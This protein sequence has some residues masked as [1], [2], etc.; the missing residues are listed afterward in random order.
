MRKIFI[1]MF[2]FICVITRAQINDEYAVGEGSSYDEALY[3]LSI[4]IGVDVD[5]VANLMRSDIR[6]RVSETF[7]ETRTVTTSLSA[8]G[9]E[10]KMEGEKY[11][12]RFNKSAYINSHLE[13]Y[14]Y[15]MSQAKAIKG[16]HIKHEKNLILGYYY[17]AYKALSDDLMRK[18]YDSKSKRQDIVTLAKDMYS[19]GSYGSLFFY[20]DVT[21]GYSIINA[22]NYNYPSLFGFKYYLD[23]KWVYPEAYSTSRSDLFFYKNGFD[24]KNYLTCYIKSKTKSNAYYIVLYE[25]FNEDTNRYEVINV[26]RNW[27]FQIFSII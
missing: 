5:Y 9:I 27:Y 6:G 22:G 26:P 25:R 21:D 23:G 12:A 10:V 1:L 20:G 13:T 18:L 19:N 2:M 16:T 7:D 8:S 15:C 14:R 3:A 4:N 17:D 24:E 11:I